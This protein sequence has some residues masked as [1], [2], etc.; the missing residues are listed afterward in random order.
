MEET[1]ELVTGF[2][3]HL[4]TVVFVV[5][6]VFLQVFVPNHRYVDFLKWL[7][8]SLLAYVAVLFAVHVPWAKWRCGQ[9]CQASR[10]MPMRQQSSSASSAPRSAPIC[11]SGR[12]R[13]DAKTRR[14]RATGG[15]E[16]AAGKEL[17]RIG[18]DTW[19][20]T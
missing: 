1:A 14:R 9:S 13:G 10:S 7:T 18:W 17:G 4:M 16:R 5:A 6:T 20:G 2:D 8:L 3:R 19:S 15:D 12:N 11:S